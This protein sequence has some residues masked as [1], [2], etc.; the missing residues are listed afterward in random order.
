MKNKEHW[1]AMAMTTMYQLLGNFIT[2]L[3]ILHYNG[4]LDAY[5]HM[6]MRNPD[7][8]STFFMSRNPPPA[9]VSSLDDIVE[10][11][12]SDASPV[13]ANAPGGFI[14]RYIHSEILKRFSE[15]NVVVHSHSPLVVPYSAVDLPLKPVIHLAGF[16]GEDVPVFDIAKNYTA[17]DT[18]DLLVRSVPLGAA[19]AA[20][21]S[22]VDKASQRSPLADHAVVLIRNH[23]FTT[24]AVALETAVFQAIYTQVNAQ[25]QTGALE[26]KDS[27]T[28]TRPREG[29]HYLAKQQAA[30][31]W[32]SNMGTIQRP[33]A[34]WVRQV[35]VS[36]LY[37]NA[38]D[39]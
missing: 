9:L 6:S 10:Y 4:V 27:G 22:A 36:P 2:G 23:G 1:I 39:S 12:V 25:V 32:D 5:G 35:K 18:Q 38:L 37:V 16:L 30:D 14:E 29:V 11:H 24:C 15:V 19:L 20:E 28:G 3:H 33:Y 26:L 7:N 13:D 17:N 31:S 21:F 8:S 34:L